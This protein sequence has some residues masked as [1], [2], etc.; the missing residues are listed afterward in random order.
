MIALQESEG[1]NIVGAAGPKVL[2]HRQNGDPRWSST[3]A[4]AAFL[5]HSSQNT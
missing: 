4:G 1:L 5:Q 3:V 2:I